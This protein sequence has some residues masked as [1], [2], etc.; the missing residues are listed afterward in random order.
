MPVTGPWSF[1][2]EL[3][4]FAEWFNGHRPHMTLGASTPNEVY[5]GKPSEVQALEVNRKRAIHLHVS[6]LHG[7]KHLPIVSLKHAA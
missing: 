6:F 4:F 7:R 1:R 2:N 5:S 3:P